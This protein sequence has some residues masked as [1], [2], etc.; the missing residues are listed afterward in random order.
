MK[1]LNLSGTRCFSPFNAKGNV[2][3]YLQQKVLLEKNLSSSNTENI[4]NVSQAKNQL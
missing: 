2:S 3:S 1:W 4:Q